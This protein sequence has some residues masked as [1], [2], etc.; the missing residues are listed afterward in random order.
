MPARRG[1]NGRDGPEFLRTKGLN[2]HLALDNQA[3]ANRLHAAS[4]FRPGQLAPQNRRQ[5]EPHQIIQSAACEIGFDQRLVDLPRARHSFGHG[6]FGDGI[7][8]HAADLF[9][10]LGNDRGQRFGQVPRNGFPLAVRVGGK[11]QFV[12]GFQR[13]GDGLDMLAAVGG[14]FPCHREVVVGVD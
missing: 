7:K 12:I 5:G 2:L 8:G 10:A 13:V 9:L 6:G 11:D 4:R 3:Q 1:K 14:H